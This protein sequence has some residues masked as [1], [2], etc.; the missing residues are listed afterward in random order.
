MI[1]Q[2]AGLSLKLFS[3]HNSR[4]H[5]AILAALFKCNPRQCASLECEGENMAVEEGL[6]EGEVCRE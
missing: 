1:Q 3:F 2:T 4:P 6:L 5:A